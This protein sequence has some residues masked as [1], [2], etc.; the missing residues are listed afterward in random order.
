MRSNNKILVTGGSGFIGSHIVDALVEQ[1][2]THIYALDNLSGYNLDSKLYLN[3]N[4][5]YI[6]GDISDAEFVDSLFKS[7]KFDI[8]FHLAA[9]ANVPFS[10]KNPYTDFRYNAQGSFNILNA[11]LRYSV[12]KVVYAST[13]AIYGNPQYTPID[14]LHPLQPISNYGTTKMYGERLGIAYY[15]T[16]GLPFTALRVF[17]TYGPRQPRYVIYDLVKKLVM[18]PNKLEV[19]GT[20]NQIR[21]YCYIKDTVKAFILASRKEEAIGEVFNIAGGNPTSIKDLVTRM[22]TIL[23]LNPLITYTGT[24]WKGDI[25][26]LTANINKIKTR[27]GFEHNYTIDDGMDETIKW[28]ADMN[29]LGKKLK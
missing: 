6:Y 25:D 2:G 3:E 22:I 19:L 18:N 27:L 7:K 5:E 29:D 24:S 20:G 13:A 15:H 1:E 10:D 4:C 12:S 8:I 26:I 28:F 21:D 23:G 14:E 9:N 16:Y 17:N 11:S